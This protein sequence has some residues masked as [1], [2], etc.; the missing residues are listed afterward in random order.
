MKDICVVI[1]SR[2]N[3]GRIKSAL[4]AIE[5]I[6]NLNLQIVL[7]A[8]ALLDKYGEVADVIQNDGFEVESEAYTTIEGENPTT[9]AKSTGLLLLELTTIFNDLDP[10]VVLTVGDKYETMSTAIAATYMN[11]PL[12]HTM[13]GEVSGTI[14]ESIRHAITR[15]AHVHFVTNETSADRLRRWGEEEDRIHTVGCPGMDA[16]ENM[17]LDPISTDHLVDEYGG[18]GGAPNLEDDYLVVMQHPVTTEYGKGEAHINETIEAIADLEM[19]TVWFWPNVDAG[20]NDI[21]RGIRKFREREDPD[22]IHFFKNI[23]VEDYNRLIANAACMVGNT[24]S[25]IREGSFLGI[26]AVNVGTRQRGRARSDN[27]INVDYDADEIRDGIKAQLEHGPYEPDDLYGDGHAGESIA[28]ILSEG[29]E[30]TLQ[31]QLTY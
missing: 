10:D 6:E 27:V 17:D 12:A 11:I 15:L 24:S 16:V 21:A 25:G 30:I 8:S 23:S 26:P 5:A 2:A 29:G 9:M 20:S 3:Y 7:G 28:D 13:G 18:V 1:I 4:T 31:K 14:D 22:Y 19:P